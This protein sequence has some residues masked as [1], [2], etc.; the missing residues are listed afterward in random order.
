MTDTTS[1]RPRG[2]KPTEED[3]GRAVVYRCGPEWKPEEGIITSFNDVNVF[4]RYTGKMHSQA[5]SPSDL[6]W[7]YGGNHE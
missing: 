1:T 5:T 7:A 2:I 4:V 3:I 6:D